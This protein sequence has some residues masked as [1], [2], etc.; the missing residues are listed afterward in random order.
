MKSQS[1]RGRG[2]PANTDKQGMFVEFDTPFAR[3]IN[4]AKA[5]KGLGKK[6]YLQSLIAIGD[7]QIPNKPKL[8]R[9]VIRLNGRAVT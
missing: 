3:L 9:L 6:Q 5:R 2:R 1:E 7:K 4:T 8:P